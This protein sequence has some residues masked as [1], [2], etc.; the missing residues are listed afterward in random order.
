[1]P[2]H[3]APASISDRP[4][5]PPLPDFRNMGVLLR[6]L[7]GANLLGL[8]AALIMAGQ[9]DEWPERFLDLCFRLESVLL[10]T[11]G[12]LAIS[13][14]GLKRLP[15]GVAYG[16]VVL[17]TSTMTVLFE[18]VWRALWLSEVQH[19]GEVMRIALLAGG[20]AVRGG[21]PGGGWTG[22]DWGC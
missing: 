8:G 17:G 11:L 18:G 7:V 21:G 10:A 14:A 3:T 19:M 20:G 2:T 12:L 5:P 6:S 9:L 4:A 22:R 15:L 13:S 1:M 16:V